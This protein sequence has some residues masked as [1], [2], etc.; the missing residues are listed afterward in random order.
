MSFHRLRIDVDDAPGRLGAIAAA[1]GRLGANIIDVDVQSVVGRTSV[2]EVVVELTQPVDLP[3][4]EHAVRGA[5]GTLTDILPTREHDLRDRA[6]SVLDVATWLLEGEGPSRSALAEAARRVVGAEL[7][8]IASTHHVGAPVELVRHVLDA[9]AP[10]QTDAPVKRLPG[11]GG[12]TWWLGVPIDRS[13]VL[14]V[15]RRG[16]RF[17][18]TETARV[19]AL[20]RLDQA[21]HRLRAGAVPLADGGTVDLRDLTI[22]DLGALR[23]LHARCQPISLHRRY[24]SA[25]P[26]PPE[27]VLRALADVDGQRRV[28]LAATIGSEIVGMAH[29]LPG[30]DGEVELAFLV[31]DGHQRRGVGSLLFDRVGQRLVARGVG[32]AYALTSSDNEGM[33]RLMGHAAGRASTWEAGGVVRLHARFATD[34]PVTSNP[35]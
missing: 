7:G 20:V 29:A 1:L 9:N 22:D 16:A 5:G 13:S 25:L 11:A 10:A 33:R 34:A 15:I 18:F 26:V 28:G 32:Q 6:T 21:R 12:S 3:A 35:A 17:T 31:E 24:F 27:R 23:R 2:D 8:W 4:I 14:V 30:E 19:Q